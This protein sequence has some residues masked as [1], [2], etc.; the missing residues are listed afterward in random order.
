METKPNTPA[1]VTLPMPPDFSCEIEKPLLY[2]DFIADTLFDKSKGKEIT[3]VTLTTDEINTFCW[4]L[5]DAGT[6]IHQMN[7]AFYSDEGW[8]QIWWENRAELESCGLK[9]PSWFEIEKTR[10]A[11]K[12]EVAA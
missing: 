2:V 4:M 9:L 8:N 3:G 10:E 5:R 7:E 1:T 6:V 12:A 11:Q